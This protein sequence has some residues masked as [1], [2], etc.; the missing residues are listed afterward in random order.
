MPKI[1][2]MPRRG[3]RS[4]SRLDCP[5]P[6]GTTV[7]PDRLER[8]VVGDAAGVERVVEAVGDGVGGVEA[9]DRERLAADRELA[10]WSCWVSPIATGSP[11]VPEV[12]WRRTRSFGVG[13]QV[14]AER[15]LP[16][17]ARAQ[18][19]LGGEGE[20]GELAAALDALAVEGG[21]RLEVVELVAERGAHAA[22]TASRARTRPRAAISPATTSAAPATARPVIASS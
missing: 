8:H 11:V 13:A 6:T 10:S 19:V 1:A 2:V 15:R 12:T 7:A 3:I 4:S 20:L 21:A 22:A 9:G 16:V 5:T 17:L 18:L 14:L